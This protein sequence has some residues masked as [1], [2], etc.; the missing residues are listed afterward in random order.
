MCEKELRVVF[1]IV[2]V[3]HANRISASLSNSS[4]ANSVTCHLFNVR[5]VMIDHLAVT[6][7]QCESTLFRSGWST[8]S[9]GN[10]NRILTIQYEKKYVL[11]SGSQHRAGQ[12]NCRKKIQRTFWTSD[13]GHVARDS[14]RHPDSK[15]GERIIF[16]SVVN[17]KMCWLILIS[18]GLNIQNGFHNTHRL[19]VCNFLPGRWISWRRGPSR[20][21]N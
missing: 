6:K 13:D 18:W 12:Y 15:K 3:T 9:L 8:Y 20:H 7:F 11:T 1:D 10:R 2:A 4:S 5:K 17:W 21:W 16:I 14:C 19:W